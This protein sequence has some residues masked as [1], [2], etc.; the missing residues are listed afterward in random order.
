MERKNYHDLTS[1]Y[2]RN[3]F[4]DDVSSI[5][6]ERHLMDGLNNEVFWGNKYYQMRGKKKIVPL[7][8]K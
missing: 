8:N 6:T 5:C 1:L 2:P 3:H 4:H 7:G